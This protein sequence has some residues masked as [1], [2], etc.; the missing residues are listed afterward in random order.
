MYEY[1]KEKQY[2]FTEHGQVLFIQ[3]R[4]RAKSLIRQAGAARLH[5]IV[6]ESSGDSWHMMACVDR[7]VELGELREIKQDGVAGQFRVFVAA[8]EL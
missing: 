6:K 2:V 7:M 8:K 4:D 5:E 3:I 1:E